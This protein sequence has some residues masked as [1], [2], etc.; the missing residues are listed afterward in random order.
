MQQDGF[1][2][3]LFPKKDTPAV[4]GDFDVTLFPKKDPDAPAAT[5]TG[6]DLSLFPAKEKKKTIEEKIAGAIGPGRF[7]EVNEA[8]KNLN[9]VQRGL[10][11][12]NYPKLK[13]AEGR[14]ITHR[15]AA[16]KDEDGRWWV[17]PTVIQ[18]PQTGELKDLNPPFVVLRYDTGNVIIENPKFQKEA[19]EYAKQTGERIEIF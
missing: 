18:D 2:I 10:T 14:D 6:L 7:S 19:F 3:S 16:E 12:D 15:L 11:P 13:D 8:N 1:D 9:F 5:S 4:T 17:F